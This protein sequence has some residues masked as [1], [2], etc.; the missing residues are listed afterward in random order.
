MDWNAIKTY[1]TSDPKSQGFASMNQ[2]Q[3]LANLNDPTKGGNT[4]QQPIPLATMLTFA[5]TNGIYSKFAAVNLGNPLYDVVQS[6]LRM[7]SGAVLS[8][9]MTDPTRQGMVAALVS[10][11][12][13]TSTDATDLAA[14]SMVPISQAQAQ[15][16]QSISMDDLWRAN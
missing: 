5:A 4:Q 3:I 14:L 1:V 15:W 12:V 2:N 16:G 7:L 10:G 11:G 8:F 6:A 13:I 9:D